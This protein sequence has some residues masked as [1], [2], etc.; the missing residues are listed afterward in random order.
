MEKSIVDGR[1][2]EKSNISGRLKKKKGKEEEKK[3]KEERRR[4][5]WMPSSPALAARALA[6]YGLIVSRC[7]P[8]IQRRRSV[9]EDDD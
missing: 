6:T 2:M 1:L 4:S 9:L 5:T 7:R 3:K 8:R